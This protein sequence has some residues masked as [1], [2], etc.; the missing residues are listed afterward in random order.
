LLPFIK[1]VD[2]LDTANSEE[3]PP[4]AKDRHLPED[5]LASY[6]KDT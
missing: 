3:I 6:C 1:N 5:V 4:R 2:E